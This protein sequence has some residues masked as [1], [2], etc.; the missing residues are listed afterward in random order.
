VYAE[1]LACGAHGR[2]WHRH[3]VAGRLLQLGDRAIVRAALAAPRPCTTVEPDD[4]ATYVDTLRAET[5]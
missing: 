2:A 4:L 5:P 1:L 3:E